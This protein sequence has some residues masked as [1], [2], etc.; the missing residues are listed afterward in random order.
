MTDV[1]SAPRQGRFSIGAALQGSFAVLFRNIGSFVLTTAI[2]CIPVIVLSLA[3][4]GGWNVEA[5]P[6]VTDILLILLLVVLS[7]LTYLATTAAVTYGTV[8]D[9][10]GRR[11][12]IGDIMS[13][14]IAALLSALGVAV[15][16]TLI[17]LAGSILL[18]VPGIIAMCMLY[19]ALPVAVVERPGVL[20]SLRRSRELTKGNRWQIFAL[21]IVAYVVSSLLQ[22]L[23]GFANLAVAGLTDIAIIGELPGLLTT[24][25]SYAWSAVLSAVAYHQLRIAK[26]GVDAEEIAAVF[27]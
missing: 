13:H 8:Q 4:G 24:V 16:A 17:A 27:D 19:V 14:T 22:M 25:L 9:L 6:T 20:G 21:F 1:A 7:L 23:G 5:E 15:L 26:D 12:G 18:V 3:I 11:A 10:R 2:I